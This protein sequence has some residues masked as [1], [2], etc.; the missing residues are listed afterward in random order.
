MWGISRCSCAGI[1]VGGDE[2]IRLILGKCCTVFLLSLQLQ[3]VL[4]FFRKFVTFEMIPFIVISRNQTKMCFSSTI[5]QLGGVII[6]LYNVLFMS[7]PSTW[8]FG[9]FMQLYSHFLMRYVLIRVCAMVPVRMSILSLS[10]PER[11]CQWK[12]ICSLLQTW[13]QIIC[14][15]LWR[16]TEKKHHKLHLVGRGYPQNITF[17][18]D[19]K[20]YYTGKPL[21]DY[22]GDRT[23]C[24]A[25]GKATVGVVLSMA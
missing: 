2:D 20:V 23:R 4:C 19:V 9:E 6:P 8:D 16:A 13:G 12:I 21:M 11:R 18:T 1:W 15:F 24:K 3:H 7:T 14:S 5:T 25:P 22:F 17:F 10:Y